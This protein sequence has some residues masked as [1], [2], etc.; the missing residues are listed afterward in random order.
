MEFLNLLFEVLFTFISN[1]RNNYQCLF[2]VLKNWI[3][4]FTLDAPLSLFFIRI[5]SIDDVRDKILKML[6][7]ELC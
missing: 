7:G 6:K 4:S 1:R 2:F 5:K 3:N